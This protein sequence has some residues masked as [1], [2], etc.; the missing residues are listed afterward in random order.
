MHQPFAEW[1]PQAQ[2]WDTFE[3]DLFS[4]RSVPY[5]ATWPTSGS[6]R[7]GRVCER[8]RSARAIAESAFSSSA[9]LPTPRAADGKASMTA[10]AARRHVEDGNGSLAEVLGSALDL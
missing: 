3:V 1:N 10:P 4:G 8:P 9:T 7:N 5:S 6:M 2:T